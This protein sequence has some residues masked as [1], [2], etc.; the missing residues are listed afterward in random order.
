MSKSILYVSDSYSCSSTARSALEAFDY[1]VITAN[2]SSQAIA[3]LF[4]IDSVVAVVL[5]DQA[6]EQLSLEAACRIRAAFPEVPIIL[7]SCHV[8]P[9]LPS[10]VDASVCTND[11]QNLTSALRYL[12]R[13]NSGFV[14]R[15]SCDSVHA[16]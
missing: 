6:R 13:T 2:S 1:K 14:E 3:L 15:G 12:L 11:S 7:L 9:H 8:F 10:C 4:L 5:D 16:A